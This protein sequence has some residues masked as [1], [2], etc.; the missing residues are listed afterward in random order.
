[1]GKRI[2]T[3]L[4]FIDYK[5]V[6][7]SIFEELAPVEFYNMRS[8][9]DPPNPYFSDGFCFVGAQRKFESRF[10]FFQEIFYSEDDSAN[11]NS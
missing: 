8:L 7:T 9:T 5:L 1:M 6:T 11:S 3:F 2:L 4:Q 10:P